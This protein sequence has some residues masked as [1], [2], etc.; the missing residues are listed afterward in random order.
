MLNGGDDMKISNLVLPALIVGATL[1]MLFPIMQKA[2][3]KL[4]PEPV[5]INEVEKRM[6]W[7]FEHQKQEEIWEIEGSIYL[8]K[9]GPR[10]YPEI[11]GLYSRFHKEEF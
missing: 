7:C 9:K 5:I 6:I 3:E 1:L 4:Q 8:T 10:G 11:V 2:F